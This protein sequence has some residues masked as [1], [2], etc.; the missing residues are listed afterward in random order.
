M[1]K[2]WCLRVFFPGGKETQHFQVLIGFLAPELPEVRGRWNC[3]GNQV[4]LSRNAWILTKGRRLF[5]ENACDPTPLHSHHSAP[6][7]THLDSNL[8]PLCRLW[9]NWLSI[10]G[11][12][13][14]KTWMFSCVLLIYTAKS[15]QIFERIESFS[16][17]FFFSNKQV[18]VQS[19]VK[20]TMLW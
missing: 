14:L 2:S 10:F 17:F 3:E 6:C 12:F 7:W 18:E 16:F 9:T 8:P 19:A 13:C 11:Q 20:K 15:G 5:D 4:S 1:D